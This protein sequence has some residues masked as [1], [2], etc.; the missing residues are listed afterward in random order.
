MMSMSIAKRGKQKQKTFKYS[1]DGRMTTGK[2]HLIE[3]D[4]G[5]VTS[6]RKGR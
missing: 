2:V 6:T 3:Q 1:N 4:M 5:L